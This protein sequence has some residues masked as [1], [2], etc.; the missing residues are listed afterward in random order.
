MRV[1]PLEPGHEI[2]GFVQLDTMYMSDFMN[3]IHVR[4]AS[5]EVAVSN[6]ITYHCLTCT[7][8]ST[9]RKYSDDF[10]SD[11]M[12]AWNIEI[13]TL[14]IGFLWAPCP[15]R[16]FAGFLREDARNLRLVTLHAVWYLHGTPPT[17]V[18]TEPNLISRRTSTSLR[19]KLRKHSGEI[20][21]TQRAVHI[22]RLATSA[23][24]SHDIACTHIAP[25]P[26]GLHAWHPCATFYVAPVDNSRHQN[27]LWAMYIY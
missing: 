3:V 17:D 7:T 9:N 11:N 18:R 8:M 22:H 10:A 13:V 5:R 24:K 26:I 12:F 20:E 1:V 2:N 14:F 25:M 15:C 19:F 4:D 16:H 27:T 23:H 21:I 6:A